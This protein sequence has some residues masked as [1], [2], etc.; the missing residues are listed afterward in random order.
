MLRQNLTGSFDTNIRLFAARGP[1]FLEDSDGLPGIKI[2][3]IWRYGVS[4]GL[5]FKF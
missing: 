5:D 2:T 3:P 1:S 4:V